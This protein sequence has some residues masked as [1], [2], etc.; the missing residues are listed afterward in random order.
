M[1]T[2]APIAEPEEVTDVSRQASTITLEES[3]I[4]GARDEP[5]VHVHFGPERLRHPLSALRRNFR[6]LWRNPSERVLERGDP[7]A[8]AAD[9]EAKDSWLTSFRKDPRKSCRR[10]RH[11][12][13]PPY[14]VAGDDSSL[15]Q[16]SE[17]MTDR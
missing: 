6:R 1:G 14:R 8:A 5:D 12:F 10:F 9:D 4:Q 15:A 7:V 16:E 17:L 3:P 11:H 2:S 13:C